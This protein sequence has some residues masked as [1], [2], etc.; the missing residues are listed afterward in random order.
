MHNIQVSPD[1]QTRRRTCIGVIGAIYGWISGVF[2]VI[3]MVMLAYL[4]TIVI[5]K[6]SALVT[7]FSLFKCA[8]ETSNAT[9]ITIDC[10]LNSYYNIL[11][12]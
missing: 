8:L 2:I 11:H 10:T 6:N 7:H 5:V 3:V 9:T 4:S 12:H 1:I